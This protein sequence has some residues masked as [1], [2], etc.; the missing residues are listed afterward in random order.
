MAAIPPT[1]P[2]PPAGDAQTPGGGLD[3]GSVLAQMEAFSNKRTQEN[4]L[5]EKQRAENGSE[6]GASTRRT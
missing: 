4:L 1:P 2:T 6:E 5:T 3:F